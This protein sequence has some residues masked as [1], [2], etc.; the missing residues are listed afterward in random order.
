[1]KELDYVDDD[2]VV[3][4]NHCLNKN[5]CFGNELHRFCRSYRCEDYKPKHIKNAKIQSTIIEKRLKEKK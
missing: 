2:Y 3:R 1:M 5:N 4:V